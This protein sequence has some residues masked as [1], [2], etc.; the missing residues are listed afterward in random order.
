MPRCVPSWLLLALC[1]VLGACAQAERPL[2]LEEYY[3]FCWPAQ[4][5]YDC[6]DDN[7]CQDYKDYLAQEHQGKADCLAGCQML[8]VAKSNAN[9]YSCTVPI[10]NATNWCESYCR[11]FYDAQQPGGQ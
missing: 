6:P 11:R 2:S 1:A 4:I 9:T 8:Y 5:D 3:G 7:L 10:R